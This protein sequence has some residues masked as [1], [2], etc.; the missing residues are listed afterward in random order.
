MG[1]KNA[2]LFLVLAIL[3]LTE[4]LSLPSDPTYN[5][6]VV[7]FIPAMNGQGKV[8]VKDNL[9][10]MKNI[11][12]SE[13]TKDLDIL[14]FPEFVLN[15]LDMMTFVPDPKDNIVPCELPNYDWFLTELSCAVRSRKLYVVINIVEKFE[16]LASEEHC[17]DDGLKKYNTNIVFDRQGR[18]I[19]R[20]RKTHL[21]RYEWYKESVLPQ[22]E[23]ATFTTDFGVTFGHF[24]CFDMLF[25]EPA[26]VLIRQLNITDI[27][28]PTYWFSELPFLTAVQLQ[29][30]W[31]FANN[32]NLLA[33]D[34]SYPAG[35]NTG[36]G[37]FAGRLG[38]LT[39]VINEVPTTQLLTAKVPKR[40]NLSNYQLPPVVK[41][42]FEPKL[43][44]NRY[45][46]LD[47]LRDYNVDIFNTSLL[48]ESFTQ[49]NETLC[50]HNF[51]CSFNVQRV[52]IADSIK[53]SS[54]RYRLAAYQGSQT[55]FQRIDSSNQSVCALIACT[56]SELYTCGHIFPESV[57]V[58][59][60]YYFSTINITGNFIKSNRRLIM[61][62]TVNSVML[63]LT[64]DSFEWKELDSNSSTNI[65][66]NLQG[67]QQDLLTFGIW[68]N[69]YSTVK[70][71]HN[72]YTVTKNAP[73]PLHNSAFS[74]NTIFNNILVLGL[75]MF[76][77]NNL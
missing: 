56:G 33:A 70:N 67:P 40:Q 26:M 17:D 16:C 62:S 42:L 37:I 36:S 74:L 71:A 25:Y 9:K 38:R 43:E 22:A 18:V 20:Y 1:F 27:V 47:L 32:V 11:I 35:Q 58:G 23:L 77:A 60:K 72:L 6:G 41:P 45:T 52:K 15:N 69:Y 55:T 31:A 39:A 73:K 46:K 63:P 13:Q 34:G 59:N 14:V 76:V 57:L 48:E 50:H 12:E 29:E 53:H 2:M 64:V 19:S 4:Q 68:A 51:C 24:I 54:Y 44:S 3:Q 5:A 10:R 75:L 61:P 30:G 21:Y 28:Y 49:V 66:M 7:E 8:L 65:Q